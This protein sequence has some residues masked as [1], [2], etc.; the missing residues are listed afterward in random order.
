MQNNQV[1]LKAVYDLVEAGEI[2]GA[3][4]KIESFQQ[5]NL[6]L[7]QH[8]IGVLDTR[9]KL[10]TAWRSAYV[11]TH[12]NGVA[13]TTP[14]MLPAHHAQC[15]PLHINRIVVAVS[16]DVPEHTGT[17]QTLVAAAMAVGFGVPEVRYV[18]Q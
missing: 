1:G 14:F 10:D 16:G 11:A 13:F 15:Y 7:H 4:L 9:E 12:F 2:E 8:F 18:C 5:N 17:V 6:K 3:R